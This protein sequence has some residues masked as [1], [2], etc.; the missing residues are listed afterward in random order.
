MK[1]VGDVGDMVGDI[2]DK[3]VL[4]KIIES[5]FLLEYLFDICLVLILLFYELFCEYGGGLIGICVCV[6]LKEGLLF[7][8]YFIVLILFGS[9][10][11]F[12]KLF[13]L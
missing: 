13:L 2:L 11:F 10:G 5:V 12:I 1:N 3:G 9:S 7:W 8:L 6:V 4:C